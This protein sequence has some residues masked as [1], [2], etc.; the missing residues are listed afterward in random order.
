MLKNEIIR[1]SPEGEAFREH[2]ISLLTKKVLSEGEHPQMRAYID[3]GIEIRKF[4]G[5]D[6]QGVLDRLGITHTFCDF[7]VS[8]R[9]GH[10]MFSFTSRES[11]DSIILYIHGGAYVFGYTDIY[12]RFNEALAINCNAKVVAPTYR[13][14]N[15]SDRGVYSENYDLLVKEYTAL[16]EE[17]KPIF[18]MGDSSGGAMA[19]RLCQILN[20]KGIPAPAGLI[21][22]SPFVDAAFDDRIDTDL[23]MRDITLDRF[24]LIEFAKL[25]AGDT[26]LSDPDISPLHGSMDGMPPTLLI[27]ATDEIF[28]PSNESLARKIDSAGG[29]VT[30]VRCEG[31]YHIFPVYTD[32]PESEKVMRIMK[33]FI[34]HTV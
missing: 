6:R 19:V 9:D 34:S 10:K 15:G 4:D 30:F 21:A 25:W 2:I 12:F 14:A 17:G 13:L 27:A 1:M 16:L 28:L 32:L 29:S 23:E 18:L 31:S 7:R 22:I 11:Y 33:E 3:S 26:Q 20:E 5:K 24:G 8:D